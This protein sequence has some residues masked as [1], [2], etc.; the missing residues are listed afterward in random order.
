MAVILCA[1][2]RNLDEWEAESCPARSAGRWLLAETAK[3]GVTPPVMS[4]CAADSTVRGPDGVV[5]HTETQ[6]GT[7]R[8]P[9]G[10]P[11][12]AWQAGTNRALLLSPRAGTS[13]PSGRTGRGGRRPGRMAGMATTTSSWTWEPSS[14]RMGQVQCHR[15]RCLAPLAAPGPLPP[16]SLQPWHVR[17]LKIW[18]TPK[19]YKQVAGFPHYG[20]MP[21]RFLAL[22]LFYSW[23]N[24]AE[25]HK[26]IWSAPLWR[27]STLTLSLCP[28][29]QDWPKFLILFETHEFSFCWWIWTH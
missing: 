3:S 27:P 15:P 6:N 1:H 4:P 2:S 12:A 24:R 11:R 28:I 8:C 19:N 10:T 25:R 22:Y 20:W 29:F 5:E 7:P 18:A 21:G 9:R 26:G 14:S 13:C 17:T 23:R 16:V